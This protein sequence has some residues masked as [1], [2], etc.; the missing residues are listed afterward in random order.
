MKVLLHA[1]HEPETPFLCVLSFLSLISCPLITFP[2]SSVSFYCSKSAEVEEY[3]ADFL[4]WFIS[5]KLKSFYV[6]I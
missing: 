5:F 4:D 6:F 2:P 3:L 1:C